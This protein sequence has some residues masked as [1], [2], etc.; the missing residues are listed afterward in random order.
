M[1]PLFLLL[2]GLE[3]MAKALGSRLACGIARQAQRLRYGWPEQGIAER[4]QD[5]RQC[6]FRDMMG[7][8]TDGEL[9]NQAADRIQDR[10]EGVAV[11]GEDHP[12]GERPSPF[13]AER[14]EAL[15]DDDPGIRFA[16]ARPFD[17]FGDACVD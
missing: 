6:A 9:R 10:V 7:V 2:F 5:Q 8:V 14:I 1:V 11:A 16:G 12:G 13:A 17:R 4:I 15:V 3:T